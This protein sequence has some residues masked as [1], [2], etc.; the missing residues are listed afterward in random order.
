LAILGVEEVLLTCCN[1]FLA[2]FAA[3]GF[4]NV[5]SFP[6]VE[7]HGLAFPVVTKYAGWEVSITRS[8]EGEER[9]GGGGVN[10]IE[11]ERAGE[12]EGVGRGKE[13]EGEEGAVAATKKAELERARTWREEKEMGRQAGRQDR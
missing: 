5:R 12:W 7:V 11:R 2:A 6:G 1:K 10:C 3:Q 8:L 4:G 9:R 13:E